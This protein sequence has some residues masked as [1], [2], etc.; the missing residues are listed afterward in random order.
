MQGEDAGSKLRPTRNEIFDEKISPSGHVRLARD[1][2]SSS[3]SGL[4]PP[5]G[6]LTP[7]Y[8][9]HIIYIAER[10]IQ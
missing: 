2:D 5:S 6:A 3:P 8:P 4:Q 7:F 1:G 9:G 10:I